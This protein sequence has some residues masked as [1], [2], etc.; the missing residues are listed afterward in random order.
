MN[1]GSK[2][3]K[4][5]ATAGTIYI[6]SIGMFLGK[7][8]RLKRNPPGKGSSSAQFHCG[9]LERRLPELRTACRVRIASVVR[10]TFLSA[11]FGRFV[12]RA[13]VPLPGRE[14]EGGYPRALARM[15]QP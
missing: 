8:R 14:R 4:A 15:T 1:K 11:S 10:D 6:K 5:S 9:T 7:I 2:R 3:V 12:A 13:V